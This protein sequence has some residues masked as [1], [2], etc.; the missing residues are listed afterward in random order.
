DDFT[1]IAAGDIGGNALTGELME[2]DLKEMDG[3]GVSGIVRF[4]ERMNENT[5]ATIE[6]NGTMDGVNHPAHIHENSVA[7][8]GGVAIPFN[9]V[10]G[11]TGIGQTNI[12]SDE[13]MSYSEIVNYDGHVNVHRSG[14]DFTVIAAGDIGGN[15]LTGESMEYDLQEIDGS[16]VSGIVRFEERVNE[17]TLATIE[18]NGTMQGGSHPAHIHENSVA[19][20]GGVVVPL[21]NVDGA[22]G[23][24]QTNILADETLTYS[25]ALEYNGHVNVHKNT[26]DFTVI[27]AGD[28]GANHSE[29][30][31]SGNSDGSNDGSN[32]GDDGGND[33]DDNGGGY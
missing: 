22:T 4:E 7:E 26:D 3:S 13:S 2:Y 21:N 9:N 29:D 31:S 11:A 19:E 30:D 12:L 27:A 16:G 20:G 28:I 33:D 23:I 10:D 14:D 17:N 5:L 8:G 25:E 6:V 18:V 32:G 1:V 15:A 24:S